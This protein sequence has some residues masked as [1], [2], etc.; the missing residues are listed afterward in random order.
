MPDQGRSAPV[1][2]DTTHSPYAR[3]RPVPLTAVTLTDTFWTPRRRTNREV[4]LPAQYQLCEETGRIDNFRRAA[5]NSNILFKGRFFNDSDLYKWLEAAAWTLATEHDPRLVEL[6]DKAIAEIGPAQQPDGYLD[7]YFMFE[8]ATERWTNVDLHEL[9]CAGHLFQAAV[10]HYRATG[11]SSLLDIAT[12]LADHVCT[13]FG[14]EEQGKRVWADGHPEVEMGLVELYRTTGKRQYLDETEFFIDVRGHGLLGEPY[15]RFG[16]DYHQ[17]HKPFREL[18]RMHGHAVRAVY[19]NAGAADLFAEKGEAAI[20]AALERMWTSMTTKQMY[21]SGG[22]GAH[23]EGEA[24]GRVYELPNERAY[25]ETCAAIGSLMWAWRMLA[26]DGDARYTDLMET[27]LYNGAL[28]GLS[29][30]GQTYFYQNPLADDGMHRRESWFGTACCP[31]NI[32]RLLASLPGYFYSTSDAGI[33]VHL[34]AEGTAQ[35][36]LPDG[37]RVELVQQTRYPWDG[38][39]TMTVNG[40]GTF[41]LFIRVPGWCETGVQVTV[42]GRPFTGSIT[43][44]TYVELQRTWKP[45]DSVQ[46]HLP[47]PVRRLESH[48]YAIE[49]RDRVALMRGPLLYCIEQAD[50]AGVELRDLVLPAGAIF[51]AT[52]RS[53]MLGGVVVLTGDAE[54]VPPDAGWDNRLYRTTGSAGEAAT[55]RTVNL[56][57]IPYYAWAN[58]EPGMMR[59]WLRTR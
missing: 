12:R 50:L 4:T 11:S 22:I 48:P 2:V 23:W 9:Y 42:N 54:V 21:V 20:R 10:A 44:G 40:E 27:A 25:T 24:F 16:S 8:R 36:S 38:D 32:A 58:R 5:G 19:L 51:E 29:L 46:I 56:T 34:Y 1:V 47:M 59:V 6:V 37:Q 57:A 52:F 49:N 53:E 14:P 45:G 35:I 39:V 17:D 43:P 7:T 3:L 55:T 26:L 31:P 30:D 41:S 15:E 13:M 28:P 18:E 33:W